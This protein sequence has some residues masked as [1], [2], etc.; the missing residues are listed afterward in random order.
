MARKTAKVTIDAEG[1]DKGKV[2]VI[3]E[4]P[5]A[6]SEEWAGRALFAM[7]NAG[8]EIPDNLAEAGLAGIAAL[9]IGALTKVHFDAVKPLLD[10]MF[11]CVRIQPN[12]KDATIVR[13]LVEDDIEEVAT[14]LT[15]RK[16]VWGLHVDFSSAASSSTSGQASAAPKR[17]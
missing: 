12:P 5:A 15:L 16:A 2:F 14:R 4:M 3:T 13:E 7:L 6:Q 1:R 10:E 9:G 8:V 11:D 17:A